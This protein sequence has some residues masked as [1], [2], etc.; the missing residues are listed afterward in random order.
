MDPETTPVV[1]TVAAE[2][3]PS[4]TFSEAVEI[5][6]IHADAAVAV[7]AI[8]AETDQIEAHAAVEIAAHVATNE[9]R[10][11]WL[12]TE[13]AETKRQLGAFS[14][15]A[16]LSIPQASLALETAGEAL[17]L[18]EATAEAV[19]ETLDPLTEGEAEAVAIVE[20][21]TVEAL[22]LTET[23]PPESVADESPARRLRRR[24]KI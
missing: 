18:A 15:Q 23:E 10:L 19:V 5:A 4:D 21:E 13:L 22:P 14:T 12:E 20:P 1:V 3:P 7:A 2:T 11:T 8:E 6:A 16:N 24:I 9:E 17:E